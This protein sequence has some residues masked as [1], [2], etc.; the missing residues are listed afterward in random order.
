VPARLVLVAALASACSFKSG[1]IPGDGGGDGGGGEDADAAALCTTWHPHFFEP[2]ALP[3][4]LGDVHLDAAGSPYVFDT[5]SG[6][7]TGATGAV[8]FAN[9]EIDQAGT[10]ALVMSVNSFIVDGGVNVIV[11]GKRPL[12]VAA[13]DSITLGGM[14]DAGSHPGV[15]GAGAGISGCTAAMQGVGDDNG[16]GGSGGGG[17]GAFRGRGGNGG[18]G[19][20]QLGQGPG[21]SNLGGTGAMA[22]A[23]PTIVRGGCAG[24]ASG[25]AGPTA[26]T[27]LMN[28]IAL[29]GEGGGAIQLTARL[30]LTMSDGATISAGGQGGAGAAAGTADGGGGGGAGGYV[31]LESAAYQLG[32]VVIA[33]NGG[34]GGSSG[35]FAGM[36]AAGGDG[37]A[38]PAQANGG[39]SSDACAKAGP[40]GGAGGIF[41]GGDAD[42][43]VVAC[44]GGGGGGATGWIYLFGPA[45]T[46]SATISP[47]PTADPF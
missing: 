38:S 15:H 20:N 18:P 1:V 46:A 35:P 10:P 6:A 2:C 41:D 39:P 22:Q 23:A 24:A 13:W 40:K 44:G 16:G 34:G 4:P 17:G 11:V 7:L 36:G 21:G 19:D 27:Q 47:T 37:A 26:G 30:M 5:S 31:G 29:G 8:T 42:Q 9:V 12:I 3:D 25:I 28:A 43:T 45:N 14:I 33:A 32:S